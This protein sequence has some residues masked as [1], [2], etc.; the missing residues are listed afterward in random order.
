MKKKFLYALAAA[1]VAGMSFY[2]CKGKNE[3]DNGNGYGNNDGPKEQL[4]PE[5]AKEHLMDVGKRMIAIFKA[6]DQKETAELAEGLYEKFYEYDW[7]SVGEEFA[8]QYEEVFAPKGMPASV[9]PMAQILRYCIRTAEGASSPTNVSYIFSF[10]KDNFIYECDDETKKWVNKGKS[11]D[12]SAIVRFKDKNGVKCE[13]RCWGDGAEKTFTYSWYDEYDHINREYGGVLPANIHLYVKQGKKE[14]IRVD[15]SQEFQ[16]ND[17]ANFNIDA[18]F[19]F[20]HWTADIVVKTHQASGAFA[21][22]YEN[23]KVFSAIF[24]APDI[25]LSPVAKNENQNY[26]E[27]AESFTNK[28]ESL[29]NKIGEANGAVDIFG[30]IQ[31]KAKTPNFTQAY[32]DWLKWDNDTRGRVYSTKKEDVEQFCEIFNSNSEN[33]IYFASDVKQGE[34]RV[35]PRYDEEYREYNP[36][37]VVYFPQDGTTYAFE[38]YFYRKPFT[39]F[40]KMAEDVANQFIQLSKDL[41]EAVGGKLSFADEVVPD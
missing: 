8:N 34:V 7:E 11:D 19:A 6:E 28:Y 36:E 14:I 29:L 35:Q 4:S 22:D 30:E 10:A 39:N 31:I 1:L 37:G 18:T 20:L 13:A 26:E 40:V 33:G 3:P 32:K 16:K 9:A 17:H 12:N 2:G 5:D 41:E 27:W 21:F 15:F 38:E 23:K 24:N 25:D